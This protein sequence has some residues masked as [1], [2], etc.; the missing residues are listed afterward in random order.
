[1][2]S[3]ITM[4]VT[5]MSVIVPS[6]VTVSVMMLSVIMLDVGAPFWNVIDDAS[7]KTAMSSKLGRLLK[8][9]NVLLIGK[10]TLEA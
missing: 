2:V 10:K 6:V 5:M 7:F 1:M 3:V 8:Y 4:S 9:S